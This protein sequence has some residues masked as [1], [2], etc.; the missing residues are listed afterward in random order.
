MHSAAIE[1]QFKRINLWEY[2]R[3]PFKKLRTT[4]GLLQGWLDIGAMVILSLLCFIW[5]GPTSLGFCLLTCTFISL[6]S[7]GSGRTSNEFQPCS[8]PCSL[9][10]TIIDIPFQM[11]D[12]KSLFQNDDLRCGGFYELCIQVCSSINTKPIQ[13]YTNSFW[14]LDNIEGP[15]DKE[16]NKIQIPNEYYELQGLLTLDNYIIPFKTFNIREQEPIETGSNWFDISFYTATLDHVFGLTNQHWSER[17]SCPT[18]LKNFLLDTMRKFYSIHL[19][20]NLLS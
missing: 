10:V 16:F 3:H 8:K 12:M 2:L 19:R 17:D 13:L 7:S 6:I 15:F 1:F 14:T 5:A 4:L 20:F 11:T 9:Y 18:I